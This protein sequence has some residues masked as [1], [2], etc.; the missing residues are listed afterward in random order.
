M[1]SPPAQSGIVLAPKVHEM[2]KQFHTIMSS[3]MQA[4]DKWEQAESLMSEHTGK[5]LIC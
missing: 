5:Q 2:F 4:H 1:T 3:L